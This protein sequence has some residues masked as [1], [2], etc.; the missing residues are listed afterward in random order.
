MQLKDTEEIFAKYMLDPT[1]AAGY[2]TASLEED[3]VVGLLRALQKVAKAHGMTNVAEGSGLKRESLYRAISAS[4]NPTAKSLCS[5]LSGLGLRLAVLPASIE[6]FDVPGY[7]GASEAGQ[8]D[9]EGNE[10]CEDDL[11]EIVRDLKAQVASFRE[12]LA[13]M[14][15]SRHQAARLMRAAVARPGNAPVHRQTL[16]ECFIPEYAQPA[17]EFV[18]RPRSAS[19]KKASDVRQTMAGA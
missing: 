13:D 5:L 8:G 12:I 17:Y 18:M 1:Y 7:M 9:E 10:G 2:V 19:D 16:T 6:T 15:R 3:G 4:G 14:D 11:A